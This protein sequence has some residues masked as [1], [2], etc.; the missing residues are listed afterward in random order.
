[1]SNRKLFFFLASVFYVFSPLTLNALS[2]NSGS[3]EFLDER[4]ILTPHPGEMGRL[5]ELDTREVQADRLKIS[6]EFSQKHN[7]H[8]VLKG[9]G[10]IVADPKG[11]L[12]INPTGN[13][14]LA[15]GGT[16]EV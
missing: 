12:Y 9:A 3:L 8:L 2:M 11:V 5:T 7:C 10:T 1:M 4:K 15:T 6:R 16:G 14:C 13:P